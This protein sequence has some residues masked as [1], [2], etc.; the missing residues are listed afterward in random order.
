M[1]RPPPGEPGRPAG[2]RKRA[3]FERRFGA[4]VG[5]PLNLRMWVSNRTTFRAAC[6]ILPMHSSIA[7]SEYFV[8]RHGSPRVVRGSCRIQA[9]VGHKNSNGFRNCCRPSVG[10]A[11]APAT[12]SMRLGV[13]QS[14]ANVNHLVPQGDHDVSCT[15]TKKRL[16][17][18]PR[19]SRAIILAAQRVITLCPFEF[20][21]AKP[22]IRHNFPRSCADGTLLEGFG[23]VLTKRVLEFLHSH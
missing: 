6:S 15:E 2:C 20:A 1:K 22:A 8:V 18:R 16:F 11:W 4:A 5:D 13:G 12:L 23:S 10:I 7:G 17:D 21:P 14:L 19:K 3:A 9:A